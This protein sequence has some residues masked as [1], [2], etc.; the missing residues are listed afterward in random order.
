VIRAE[1][2]REV[3]EVDVE[4]RPDHGGRPWVYYCQ[5]SKEFLE[6]AGKQPSSD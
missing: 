1:L 4:I 6:S 5:A 3:F 2:L